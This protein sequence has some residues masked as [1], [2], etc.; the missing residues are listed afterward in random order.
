MIRLIKAFTFLFIIFSSATSFA[1]VEDMV[2]GY[3]SGS[4]D[5]NGRGLSINVTFTESEGSLDG[6]IDIPEQQAYTLPVE[7]IKSNSDSLVFQFQTGTGPAIFR[8]ELHVQDERV[9]GTFTQVGQSFP[10]Q[11]DKMTLTNG[12]YSDLPEQEIIIPTDSARISGSLL[13]HETKSPLVILV[14]GSGS[15]DRDQTVAGFPTFRLLSSSLYNRG[16]STFRYDDPGVGG[17]TGNAD[18]TLE[19]LASD[20]KEVVRHLSQRFGNEISGIF[21]AGHS[22]GGLVSGLVA[23]EIQVQGVVLLATPF[24][25]GDQ[26]IN[27]QIRAISVARGVPDEIVEQ[28]L[29]FQQSLYE[30]VRDSGNWDKV[31][32]DLYQRLEEQV[33]KLPEQQRQSL[34]DMSRFIQSQVDRQLATAKSDWFRSLIHLNPKEVFAE[35]DEPML[36]I[37]GENDTQVL[38]EQNSEA[39]AELIAEEDLRLRY[40]VLP[41][42]NHLFQVSQSGMPSE[43]GMLKREFTGEFINQIVEFIQVANSAPDGES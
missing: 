10:F 18:A 39:A 41:K 40:T 7:V 26:V 28:N 24:L 2:A 43:Y 31:E 33:N 42:A 5:L 37:F 4:I 12:L 27:D 35:V 17:S 14:S 23:Q 34:G 13:L 9:R 11:L 22:Q 6:T 21:L 16:F 20:L 30:V 1:Q 19:E 32:Q 29:E 3:W 36:A 38:P 25:R 15:Q 8:G